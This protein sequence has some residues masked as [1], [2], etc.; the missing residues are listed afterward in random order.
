MGLPH[1]FKYLDNKA[2]YTTIG[3]AKL[4]K[5]DYGE[6]LESKY[7]KAEKRM[8]QE[9]IFCSDCKNFR[10]CRGKRWRGCP[11]RAKAL[12]IIKEEL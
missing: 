2:L 6:N 4:Y 7:D 9:R 11:Y 3:R 1:G 10:N 5:K 8:R 12:K